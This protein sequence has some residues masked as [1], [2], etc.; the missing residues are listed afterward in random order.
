MTQKIRVIGL[1][2]TPWRFGVV[3]ICNFVFALTAG[4]AWL[5]TANADSNPFDM[6]FSAQVVSFALLIGAVLFFYAGVRNGLSAWKR[7]AV[8]FN[9]VVLGGYAGNQLLPLLG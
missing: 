4:G 9:A 5:P 2:L 7:E 1:S 8:F 3:A 6:L